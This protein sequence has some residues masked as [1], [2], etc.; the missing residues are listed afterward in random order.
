VEDWLDK[1]VESPALKIIKEF[2]VDPTQRRMAMPIPQKEALSL[3]VAF[4]LTRGPSFRDGVEKTMQWVNEWMLRKEIELGNLTL[5]P[6]TTCRVKVPY[7]ASVGAMGHAAAIGAES[8]LKKK[9][10]FVAPYNGQHFVTSDSPVGIGAPHNFVGPFHPDSTVF[11][12]LHKELAL[13]VKPGCNEK[14]FVNT[15]CFDGERTIDF[16]TLVV[17]NADRYVYGS[18]KNL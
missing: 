18:E 12:P 6:N 8:L 17:R 14:G 4:L 7:G 10:L 13:L 16:N 1:N 15:G 5:P 2:K 3:F 11:L 9:W